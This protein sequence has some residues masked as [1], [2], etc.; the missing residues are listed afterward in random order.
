MCQ[1][2]AWCIGSGIQGANTVH[3]VYNRTEYLFFN[4]S[5]AHRCF[6][7]A[8]ITSFLFFLTFSK[9]FEKSRVHSTVSGQKI[10]DEKAKSKSFRIK[11]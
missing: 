7:V 3:T 5:I 6:I 2:A 9:R 1:P 10:K 4:A 8:M 11:T